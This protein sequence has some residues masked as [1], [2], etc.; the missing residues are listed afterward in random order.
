VVLLDLWISLVST[1]DDDLKSVKA[2]RVL[3]VKLDWLDLELL[4]LW[5]CIVV[6]AV[7]VDCTVAWVLQVT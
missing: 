6:A 2:E 5:D 3:A 4:V 7:T 1:L